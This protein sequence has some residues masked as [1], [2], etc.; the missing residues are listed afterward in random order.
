MKD[1]SSPRQPPPPASIAARP[2]REA[3]G[4]GW[5]LGQH[6]CQLCGTPALTAWGSSS[7]CLASI[8]QVVSETGTP[9]PWT[10]LGS[11]TLA[12]SLALSGREPFL[13]PWGPTSPAPILDQ[14]RTSTEGAVQ[15]VWGRRN[16]VRD[17]PPFAGG[18]SGLWIQQWGWHL[19]G[20]SKGGGSYVRMSGNG[21]QG[22]CLCVPCHSR[23]QG[24]CLAWMS[25]LS[26][27]LLQ[28][29]L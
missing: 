6:P 7:R 26:V 25:V 9:D 23:V 27:C 2:S 14:P 28:P 20:D 3:K 11:M 22:V 12:L 15:L 17:P 8:P 4:W 24:V 1:S 16:E 5:G 10:S 29:V 13:P 18:L 19:G 21:S